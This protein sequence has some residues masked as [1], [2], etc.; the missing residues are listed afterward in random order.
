L[1]DQWYYAEG[2]KPVGPLS[3]A[4]LIAALKQVEG[5]GEVL[6]W[7]AD[8]RLW[9]RAADVPETAPHV[10]KP[11]PIPTPKQKKPLVGLGGWLALLGFG[12][13]IGPIRYV[14]NT[15]T[16]YGSPDIKLVWQRFPAAIFP[17]ILLDGAL[18]VLMLWLASLFFRQ[19]KNF[20]AFYVKVW[21]ASLIMPAIKLLAAAVI[22]AGYSGASVATL[23]QSGLDPKDLGQWFAV[24]FWGGIW[25]LYLKR[26]KRVANTFVD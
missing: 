12:L 25:V 24:F 21:L 14:V 4:D 19:S 18:V 9:K 7:N 23:I 26:S 10:L 20:P 13:V 2:E 3:L 6:V 22:I 8:Y 17:E 15:A 11:P 16:Y 5:A 1:A